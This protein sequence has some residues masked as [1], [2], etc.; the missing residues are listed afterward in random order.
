[1]RMTRLLLGAV[2]VGAVALVTPAG[3]A[4]AAQKATYSGEFSGVIVYEGCT[5]QAPEGAVTTGTWSITLHG[6]SARATF[7]IYVNGE[8]HVA[9]V[10]PNMKQAPIRPEDTFSVYGKTQ[11]GL[12][13][14]TLTGDEL[15]YSIAPYNYN[16]LSCTRVTYP[17]HLT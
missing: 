8:P 16:G 13:T 4:S 12:L 1:M 10:Y 3:V 5:T 9:Y 6:S 2:L 17:G 15:S 14:V 11:A 7:D